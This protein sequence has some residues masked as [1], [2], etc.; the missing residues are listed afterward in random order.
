MEIT[1]SPVVS[2]PTNGNGSG[3]KRIAILVPDLRGGGV[4]RVSLLLAREF[5]AHGCDVDLVL[6]RK[7]GVLLDQVPDEARVI[8][9]QAPRI[10]QGF[11]PMVRYLRAHRPD[12][13]LASMWPLTSVAVL[14]AKVAGFRGKVVVS[15][16]SALSRSPQA[17]GLPGLALRVSMKWVNGRADTVVG[18]SDGVVDGLHALGLAEDKGVT[19]YNPVEISTSTAIPAAWKDHPWLQV[20]GKSRLLAVGSLKPAKDYPTLIRSVRRL[21][22]KGTPV[23]LLILGVG[24]LH[25][26]LSAQR[27]ELGLEENVFLGGFQADPTSFYRAA[28]L[29][30]LCSAW[31]GLGNVIVEALAA[32]TPVVSTDCRSGPAE[33]LENGKWGRL[34]PVG[35]DAALASA[36]DQA[37]VATH[38]HEALQ[39]RALEFAP[40]IAAGKYLELLFPA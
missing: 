10:R 12:A 19:I 36:I 30:V 32:G 37:L 34:V 4:E 28:G 20:P 18:V 15:E 26:Q 25:G 5:L 27:K 31:E 16:H 33:I 22:D 13:L 6:L 1:S 11:L 29:F 40:E 2:K 9:L 14:A 39:R 38:D 35:D 8:D 3:N 24:P 23:R 7:H 17:Q 21:V